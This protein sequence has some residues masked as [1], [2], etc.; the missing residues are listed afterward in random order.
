M[1][2]GTLLIVE[3]N[4]TPLKKNMVDKEEDPEVKKLKI[5]EAEDELEKH[6]DVDSKLRSFVG[7]IILSIIALI[8]LA[9]L[10]IKYE[11]TFIAS[12]FFYFIAVFRA[13]FMG[14]YSVSSDFV[15]HG[16]QFIIVVVVL[17]IL[18][19]CFKP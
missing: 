5:H 17:W 7:Y 8:S 9:I 10:A 4:R 18:H 1:V 14:N 13:I 3:D 16:A 2:Y 19:K 11:W 6:E 15:Q 12:I